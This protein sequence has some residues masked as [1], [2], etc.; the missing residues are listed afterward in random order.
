MVREWDFLRAEIPATEHGLAAEDSGFGEE[1]F[2]H[3]VERAF[4]AAVGEK[5]ICAIQPGGTEIIF[6]HVSRAAG[7]EADTALDA[8]LGLVN[9]D[10]L[11]FGLKVL[12]FFVERFGNFQPGLKPSGHLHEPSALVA[13]DILNV[14]EI[15]KGFDDDE[16]GE[17]DRERLAGEFR[18]AVYID[19]A[20]SAYVGPAADVVIQ[21]RIV[22]GPDFIHCEIDR[23]E[24]AIVNFE[25]VVMRN[26]RTILRIVAEYF[27][28]YFSI[29][30]MHYGLCRNPFILPN[31]KRYDGGFFSP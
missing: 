24:R 16:V 6:V 5:S 29:V 9:R 13:S 15:A 1:I 10:A 17:V 4:I 25:R 30:I 21:A 11:I 22:M 2:R 20:A 19:R 27:E 8:S 14:V 28:S 7:L 26:A 23:K 12:E 18:L 3:V 31:R